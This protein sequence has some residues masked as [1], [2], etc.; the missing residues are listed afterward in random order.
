[1]GKKIE[2]LKISNK[3]NLIYFFKK[4]S[5]MVNVKIYMISMRFNV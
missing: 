2:Y 5:Y 3:Y 4:W 1:M